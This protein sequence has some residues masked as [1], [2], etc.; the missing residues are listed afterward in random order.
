MNLRRKKRR[1]E[2]TGRSKVRLSEFIRS[3][4]TIYT[5]MLILEAHIHCNADTR[6]SGYDE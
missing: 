6:S 2:M 4:G 5:V 1:E 3:I